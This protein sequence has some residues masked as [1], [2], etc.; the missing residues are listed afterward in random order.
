APRIAGSS[1][2]LGFV[3]RA[4]PPIEPPRAERTGRGTSAAHLQRRVARVQRRVQGAAAEFAFAAQLRSHCRR[5]QTMA[6]AI[7]DG[8]PRVTPY[9][10]IDGASTAIDFYRS[11]LGASERMRMP[12]P[13]GKIGHAELEVGDS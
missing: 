12:G 5:Y 2:R 9:L 3:R 4:G 7:P 6:K 11:V 1:T 10:Y 8:Y 13:D